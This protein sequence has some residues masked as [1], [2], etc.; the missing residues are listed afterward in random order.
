MQDPKQQSPAWFWSAAVEGL[1]LCGRSISSG[2]HCANMIKNICLSRANKSLFRSN[3]KCLN[4]PSC[5][6]E[7]PNQSFCNKAKFLNPSNCCLC[8]CPNPYSMPEPLKQDI[9]GVRKG[10]RNCAECPNLCMP[11]PPR[12]PFHSLE[13]PKRFFFRA[14]SGNECF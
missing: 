6:H 9:M 11:E 2:T 14:L 8:Q 7:C 1:R 13:W 4:P 3:G 10:S 5:R 12:F